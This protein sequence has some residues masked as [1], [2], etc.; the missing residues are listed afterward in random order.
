MTHVEGVDVVPINK[1]T[2]SCQMLTSLYVTPA[3]ESKVTE[4]NS[5]PKK[6]IVVAGRK[7]FSFDMGM[8]RSRH[9]ERNE[10]IS[11][12]HCD[13]DLAKIMKSSSK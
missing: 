13:V 3:A 11:C 4:S 1:S 6:V 8:P 9:I 7:V 10:D 12:L 5:M 2:Q